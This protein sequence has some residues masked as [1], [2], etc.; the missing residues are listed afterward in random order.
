L[1]SLR[2]AAGADLDPG[3]PRAVRGGCGEGEERP[4]SEK[5]LGSSLGSLGASEGFR[6]CTANSHDE[7]GKSKEG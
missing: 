5:E 4:G 1:P 2:S 6:V 7:K 3:R